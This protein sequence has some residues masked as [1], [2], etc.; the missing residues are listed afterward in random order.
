MRGQPDP[1]VEQIRAAVRAATGNDSPEL[2]STVRFLEREGLKLYQGESDL[3]LYEVY[4]DEMSSGSVRTFGDIVIPGR[5]TLEQHPVAANFGVH[6]RKIYTPESPPIGRGETPEVEFRRTTRA[7]ARMPADIAARLTPLGF[8]ELIYRSRVVPGQTFAA[9][10]P[11]SDLSYED[12]IIER[13]DPDSGWKLASR[14]AESYDTI[15]RMHAAGVLHG[16]LHLDN[17]MW[18]SDEGG[19]SAQPI[20]LAASALKEDLTE[21]EWAEGTFDDQNEFL[22]EAGLLQLNQ[23]ARLP[24]GCFETARR[25]ADDLFPGGIVARFDQLPL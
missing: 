21:N 13:I 5:L 2:S 3:L 15:L 12:A 10:S 6:F 4:R 14:I 8:E 7:V 11:F 22:R 20:D 1:Q 25:L 17:I 23:G 16:D 19:P 9:T 24:G 18:I